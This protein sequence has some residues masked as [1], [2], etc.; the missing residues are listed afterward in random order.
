MSTNP[1]TQTALQT[2][3]Q[4]GRNTPAVATALTW[5][6][7]P[8]SCLALPLVLDGVIALQN[9]LTRTAAANA[10]ALDAVV[11]PLG[12]VVQGIQVL[13]ALLATHSHLPGRR[14][15][16]RRSLPFRGVMSSHPIYTLLGSWHWRLEAAQR[17]DI[18][19]DAVATVVLFAKARA[20]SLSG[21]AGQSPIYDACTKIRELL[22]TNQEVLRDRR[23]AVDWAQPA[24]TSELEP[25]FDAIRR[26]VE[27]V[28]RA[29]GLWE[30]D[31]S[32]TEESEG[33]TLIAPPQQQRMERGDLLRTQKVTRLHSTTQRAVERSGLILT[34]FEPQEEYVEWVEFGEEDPQDTAA[35]AP[36]ERSLAEQVLRTRGMIARRERG[37]QLL[38][39]D[40]TR[41]TEAEIARLWH[42]LLTSQQTEV[43]DIEAVALL[44]LALWTAHPSQGQ[45]S[46]GLCQTAVV[47]R[48]D[49]APKTDSTRPVLLLDCLHLRLPV[50]RPAAQPA[51]H[52]IDRSGARPC[53]N[54]LDLPLPATVQP[55]IDALPAVKQLR[56]A[57]NKRPAPAF[58][59]PPDDLC[60]AASA[61]LRSHVTQTAGRLSLP[62]VEQWMFRRLVERRRDHALASLA[63]GRPHI[64]ADTGLHYLYMDTAAITRWVAKEQALAWAGLV[65]SDARLDRPSAIPL[66]VPLDSE[67]EHNGVGAPIV[68]RDETVRA[69]ASRLAQQLDQAR[70]QPL[71][72]D[73]LLLLHNALTAYV[74]TLLRFSLGL[75]DVGQPLPGWDRIDLHH[76]VVLLSDKDDVAA[77]ATRLV[78]LCPT[79]AEQLQVYARHAR[80]MLTRFVP[81]ELA[82]PPP[83][84]FYLRRGRSERIDRIDRPTCEMAAAIETVTGYTLPRNTGRHWL[85]S[86][87]AQIGLSGERVEFLMGHWQRGTEPW[88]RFSA[89]P[90]QTAID[91]LR[92]PL[93]QLVREAGFRV[94]RGWA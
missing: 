93:E 76:G 18:A 34:E 49:D 57:G 84:L 89:L 36:I 75:R 59:L 10:P 38:A 67:S 17:N 5:I 90:A 13:Q 20:S 61:L 52:R 8:E 4:L 55:L 26:V 46:G 43:R 27:P 83:V 23:E 60:S 58:T 3:L 7:A 19:R 32:D 21:D 40:W 12:E 24:P 82:S 47:L 81:A 87:L 62:M 64:L 9:A 92:E 80:A 63:T 45:A 22:Q 25:A 30:T 54:T 29:H 56:R 73:A 74:H 11:A 53:A 85:R 15:D 68:P 14:P 69:L 66:S 77:S 1:T 2:L 94:V 86:R 6:E 88:G 79:A 48:A 35:P 16:P 50:L 51:Y 91:A 65:Q 31:A 28:L 33:E 72:D 71:G 41:P 42:D 78:P 39:A 44:A 37:V 70:A